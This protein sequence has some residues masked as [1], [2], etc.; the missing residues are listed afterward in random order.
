MTGYPAEKPAYT[1]QEVATMM[2]FSRPTI[3]GLFKNEPGVIKILRLET[4]H[5]RRCQSVRIPH[6][7]YE[8]VVRRLTV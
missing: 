3:L 1:V 6:A 2:G 5:K 4:L 8:R 7:V